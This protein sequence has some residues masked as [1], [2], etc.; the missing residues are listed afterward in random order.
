M[1]NIVQKQ[2]SNTTLDLSG[3]NTKDRAFVPPKLTTTQRDAIASPAAG[4]VV[5]DTTLGGLCQYNGTSW[6]EMAEKSDV[7]TVSDTAYDATTWNGNLDAASKNAIRDKFESL[8][9]G[10]LVVQV[11]NVTDGALATGS[12]VIPYDDTIP[13]NTEGTQVMSLSITPT[14]ATNK[15]KIEVV[16]NFAADSSGG[17][18]IQSALFQDSVIDALAAVVK[19]QT[20]QYG[21]QL[22]FTHYMT[23]GTTSATTFKVRIGANIGGITFNGQGG[24][25]KLG[26]V[27]A[28]SITI[29]E[30]TV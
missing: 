29:T 16:A 10:G 26:G 20:Y 30:I 15:L 14:S 23:T 18:R 5:F 6:Q 12:T 27:T 1:S 9:S 2:S 3:A 28:S 24:V 13:Q 19:W 17:V 21:D 4:M 25:R 7:P 11:V 8:S 22:I